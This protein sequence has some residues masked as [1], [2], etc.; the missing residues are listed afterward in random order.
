MQ[1]TSFIEWAF[2]AVISGGVS[3][4]VYMLWRIK[5]SMVN[6]LIEIKVIAI[7]HEH[8]V[9]RNDKQDRKLED[10]EIRLRNLEA[11]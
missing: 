5:E 4:V 11:Q 2:L 9:E 7:K 8:Q 1:F 10:H 6:M 3:G